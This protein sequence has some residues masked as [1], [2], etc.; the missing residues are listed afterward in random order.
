MLNKESD[1]SM[2]GRILKV[3]EVLRI[4]LVVTCTLVICLICMPLYPCY[5][6]HMFYYLKIRRCVNT[7][8]ITKTPWVQK[9]G[10]AKKK[11]RPKRLISECGQDL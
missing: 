11:Q 1:Q 5:N 7:V 3:P 4:Y 2:F 10:V 9:S 8:S 6:L